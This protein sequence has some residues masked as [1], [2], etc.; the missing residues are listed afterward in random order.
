M[1][2]APFSRFPY[3]ADMTHHDSRG[4]RRDHALLR[5][6]LLAA[7]ELALVLSA[8]YA[9]GPHKRITA[10]ALEVLPEKE[11]WYAELGR[12]NVEALVEYCMMPDEIGVEKPAYCVDDYLV[13]RAL[14]AYARHTAPPVRDTLAPCFRRALQALRTETPVNACRQIG[15]ILHFVED[16]GAPP[17]TGPGIPEHKALEGWIKGDDISIA[18]YQPRL[19]GANDEEALENLHRRV[20]ALIEYSSQR[21]DR[22]LP[23]VKAGEAER[24]KVEAILLESAHE[25]A[26]VSADLLYTVF[27]LGLK[28]GQAGPA[29]EGWIEAPAIPGGNDK[30]A[31]VVLLDTARYE[32]L[33][34]AGYPAGDLTACATE[35]ATLAATAADAPADT[36]W[37]GRLEMR[38][39]PAGEYRLL[40]V[41]TGAKWVVS[42]P[43]KLASGKAAS[44]RV[45][46]PAC[47]P[48]GNL[49][50]NPDGRLC[51]LVP[52][53]PDRWRQ[54]TT[55]DKVTLKTRAWA[56]GRMNLTPGRYRAAVVL[57]DPAATLRVCFADGKSQAAPPTTTQPAEL[58]F[59]VEKA[60]WAA[61]AIETSK[62]W[63]QAIERAWL[64]AE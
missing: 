43:V 30:G 45:A 42:E 18:G 44:V 61:L 21:R 13:F 11:R 3:H 29:L 2:Q 9:W 36:G 32:A 5:Y 28:K 12:E 56:T 39:L 24:A 8:A 63:A 62:P 53:V 20:N 15:P 41:R 31:R 47:D 49:V 14:P 19:L 37:R 52:G 57:K 48:P 40:V 38:N 35:Y 60:T 51:Y 1:S 7:A 22:A 54:T 10:A 17:H 26:R 34:Q 4:P 64:V 23:L 25:T 50:Q 16:A 46:L 27:T 6:S 33:V 55:V 58:R 59:S